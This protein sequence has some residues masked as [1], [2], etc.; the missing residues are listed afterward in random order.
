MKQFKLE[1]EYIY[2]WDDTE[3]WDDN[4]ENPVLYDTKE[5]AQMSLDSYILD[6]NY[7]YKMGGMDSPYQ[8]DMRVTEI[9]TK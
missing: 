7:A 8:N 9:L 6:V 5:E 1:R 4:H 3:W 2:G